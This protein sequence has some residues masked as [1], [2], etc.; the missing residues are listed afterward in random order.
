M[1]RIVASV[2]CFLVLASAGG[3]A[4]APV[5]AG[6][7]TIMGAGSVWWRH[8]A[9]KGTIY[10]LDVYDFVGTY[11]RSPHAVRGYFAKISC[12]VGRRNRPDDCDFRHST[13]TRVKV[14][15]LEIDPLMNSA[16]AVVHLG[17]RRGEVTWT[18]H[19]DYNEPFLWE[20]FGQLFAPP[21][22][23]HVYANVIAFTGRDAGA[24]GD[25][26]GL[27]LKRSEFMDAGLADILFASAGACITGPWC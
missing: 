19:G 27:D 24:R 3:A 4:A 1:R 14:D 7:E 18:G 12:E 2:L 20:S 13:Y 23:G 6:G 10:Y 17:D 5:D 8:G 16:H 25:I 11:A 9:T 15:S 22:F 26:F 21:Y